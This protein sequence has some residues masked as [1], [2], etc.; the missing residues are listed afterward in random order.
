MKRR[1]PAPPQRMIRSGF[2][3]LELLVVVGIVALLL[4]ITIPAVLHVR[5]SA[6]LVECRDQ[7]RQL[8][9]ATE[10]H[11]AAKG[12]FPGSRFRINL[13]PYMER[14]ELYDKMVHRMVEDPPEFLEWRPSFLRCP[15]TPE[16]TPLAR[17]ASS[18]VV[19]QGTGLLLESDPLPAR[20]PGNGLTYAQPLKRFV[21]P[22]DITDGLS[23]TAM[24]SELP[25]G[26]MYV[27]VHRDQ[28]PV[29]NKAEYLGLVATCAVAI[30]DDRTLLVFDQAWQ[31]G[32]LLASRSNHVLTPNRT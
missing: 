26:G 13:L 31:H 4:A 19:N 27:K 6:R 12:H 30:P 9:V 10:S 21:R 3:V 8:G 1:S 29:T 32:G 23:T 25:V 7:L 22:A 11:V 24:Y 2:T 20:D 17:S 16:T 28:V 18:Y 14:Q 15:A 5:A